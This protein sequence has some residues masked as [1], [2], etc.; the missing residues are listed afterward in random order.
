MKCLSIIRMA[1]RVQLVRDHH[2][3]YASIE[4]LAKNRHM[5]AQLEL[6]ALAGDMPWPWGDW[7][8]LGFL[9]WVW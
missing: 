6:E 5:K 2:S 7:E 3:N 9:D 1:I 8:L 4:L